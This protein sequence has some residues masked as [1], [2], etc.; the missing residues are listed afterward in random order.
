M[1]EL[2]D[3]WHSKFL[4]G[5]ERKIPLGIH[6][7]QHIPPLSHCGCHADAQASQDFCCVNDV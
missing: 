3:F 7:R 6:F 1:T 5:T 4:H 2:S